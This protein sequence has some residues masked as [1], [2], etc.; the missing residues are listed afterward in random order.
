MLCNTPYEMPSTSL[1]MPLS[2]L[3]LKD[4]IQVVLFN[5]LFTTDIFVLLQHYLVLL[6]LT[7]PPSSLG[8]GH[9]IFPEC[10]YYNSSSKTIVKLVLSVSS[11]YMS[12]L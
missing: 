10:M 7:V 2:S 6:S 3:I 11:V 5:L 4:I 9:S 12:A 1:F 8:K